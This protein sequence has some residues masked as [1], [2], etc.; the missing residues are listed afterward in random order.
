M[1][2]LLM[3]FPFWTVVINATVTL[4]GGLHKN[5]LCLKP[6]RTSFLPSVENEI[7]VQA[8]DWCEYH[9]PLLPC[10]SKLIYTKRHDDSMGLHVTN[11]T[12]NKLQV[13][14]NDWAV[15]LVFS[16]SKLYARR[17]ILLLYFYSVFWSNSWKFSN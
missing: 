13:A 17:S 3:E 14:A 8:E 11:L 9:P 10:L 2:M 5:I 1:E 16:E 15:T 4:S 12:T 6:Q 7:H